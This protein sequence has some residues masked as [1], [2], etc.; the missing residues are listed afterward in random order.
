MGWI[1]VLV[2]KHA[3]FGRHKLFKKTKQKGTDP[4]RET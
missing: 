1:F 4:V 3:G 2:Y